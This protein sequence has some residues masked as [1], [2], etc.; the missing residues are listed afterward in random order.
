[1]TSS[2]NI[3]DLANSIKDNRIYDLFNYILHIKMKKKKQRAIN[4]NQI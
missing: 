2:N 1:M 3:N 4:M